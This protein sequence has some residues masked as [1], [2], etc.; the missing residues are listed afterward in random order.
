MMITV[1]SSQISY[2]L[3]FLFY[4]LPINNLHMSLEVRYGSVYTSMWLGLLNTLVTHQ[5]L[6]AN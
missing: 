1:L 3:M 6:A 5:L 2:L 4:R